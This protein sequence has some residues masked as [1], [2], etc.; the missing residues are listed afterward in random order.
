MNGG[1]CVQGLLDAG[2]LKACSF[3]RLFRP[4]RFGVDH[5][6]ASDC[7]SSD[8]GFG[9]SVRSERHPVEQQFVERRPDD[10]GGDRLRSLHRHRFGC[11]TRRG[12]RDGRRRHQRGGVVHR[13]HQ[14]VD[15]GR[16][17]L[18]RL[19]VRRAERRERRLQR[20]D[21]PPLL[22]RRAQRS[23]SNGG[24]DAGNRPA[25]GG[26][27]IRPPTFV[28]A[29]NCYESQ[30]LFSDR[31][32]RAV[33]GR[34]GRRHDDLQP[35]SV[36]GVGR[37]GFGAGRHRQ[38]Y[39]Q[40]DFG[41]RRERRK[42]GDACGLDRH[43]VRVPRLDVDGR[44]V[45]HQRR[46][47]RGWRR[48]RRRGLVRRHR[49]YDRERECVV[50]RR[51]RHDRARRE[52]LHGERRQR[53][54]HRERGCERAGRLRRIVDDRG[55]EPLQ[56]V[57]RLEYRAGRIAVGVGRQSGQLRRDGRHALIRVEGTSF[58]VTLVSVA[59]LSSP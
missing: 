42:H 11:G 2:R 27:A 28:I 10:G 53:R 56:H 30:R 49:Q 22:S 41:R 51:D 54:R 46:R 48:D 58:P 55:L 3:L 45:G 5:E 19:A 18:R 8:G 38:L 13:S 1:P 6:E 20:L 24:A 35:D 31:A 29:R 21:V 33:V 12:R 43:G 47:V 16:L 7:S 39:E 14:H 15:G 50:G 37:L 36:R 17:R 52:P 25:R 57:D 4:R 9:C 26:P 59:P 44:R 23:S 34:S 40:H 32:R